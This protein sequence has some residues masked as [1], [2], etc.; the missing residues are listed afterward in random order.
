MLESH[1]EKTRIFV[2]DDDDDLRML[3]AAHLRR[4][5]YDATEFQDGEALLD[6]VGSLIMS[7]T[8]GVRATDMIL[9]DIKMPGFSGL[10]ILTSLRHAKWV[11]PIIMVTGM[12]RDVEDK[13]FTLGA[14]ALV[15]K[16]FDMTEV[17]KMLKRVERHITPPI[18]AGSGG[19][20]Y[21]L[22]PFSM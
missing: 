6:Y 20:S 2:V 15:R 11:N 1:Q 9:L 18:Y 21:Q 10:Q 5:G 4:C 3:V 8:D 22:R 7:R 13:A 16:P 12:R 17:V 14:T 19:V